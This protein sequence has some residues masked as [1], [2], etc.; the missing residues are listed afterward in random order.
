[1]PEAAAELLGPNRDVAECEWCSDAIRLREDDHGIFAAGIGDAEPQY[2]VAPLCS[3]AC[4]E[5]YV[6]QVLADAER[7]GAFL[8]YDSFG[9]EVP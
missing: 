3:T 9:G 7:R 4:A 1:M 8:D 5:K 2:R 6:E